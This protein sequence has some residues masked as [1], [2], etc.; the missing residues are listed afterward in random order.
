LR[1]FSLH[2][3]KVAFKDIQLPAQKQNSPPKLVVWSFCAQSTVPLLCSSLNRSN[4]GPKGRY[5]D[6]PILGKLAFSLTWK[7]C[8]SQKLKNITP[9]LSPGKA[10]FVFNISKYVWISRR[11]WSFLNLNLSDL[12]N[13]VEKG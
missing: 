4:P 6:Q 2:K 1:D 13:V 3:I 9:N 8:Q 12:V 5:V 7:L 11:S 10:T